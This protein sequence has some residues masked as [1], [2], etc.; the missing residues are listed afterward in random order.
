MYRRGVW[1]SAKGHGK[2]GIFSSLFHL[3]LFVLNCEVGSG[4]ER[5]RMGGKRAENQFS[6]VM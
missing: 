1:E 5:A 3:R 6:F 4:I 2:S